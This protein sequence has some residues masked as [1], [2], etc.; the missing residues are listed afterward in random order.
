M[1]QGTENLQEW[2]NAHEPA[3]NL[4]YK[5]G[6]WDQITFLRDKVTS[7]LAKNDKEYKS[8]KANI[9]VI[10]TH[11]SKSVLLP[12][13]RLELENGTVFTIRY[14]FYNWKVSVN[15]PCDVE[16][17]FMGLFDPKYKISDVYCEGFPKEC[18]YGP[19]AENK[20]T[21]TIELSDYNHLFT[22]FWIFSHQ[23]LGNQNK[24]DCGR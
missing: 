22:F 4:I 2:A 11:V 6:Y 3:E 24:E 18:V 5:N 16:A 10:S 1:E 23:V 21:F 9:K 20:R 13:F 12:V 7:I 14:N 19:Y 15:S 8:I 17:D